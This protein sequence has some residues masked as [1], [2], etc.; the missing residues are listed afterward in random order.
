M[1]CLC[2]QNVLDFCH[3]IG[4]NG[5]MIKSFKHK[6]LESFFISGSTKGIQS[7]HSNKLRLILG[8]LNQMTCLDDI[9]IPSFRLHKLKGDKQN[10]WSITVQANWRITFEYDEK[11]ADVYIVDYQDYH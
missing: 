8:R 3:Q 4:Y 10:L 7:I 6:G 5:Y 1:C 11:S 9:N 2:H